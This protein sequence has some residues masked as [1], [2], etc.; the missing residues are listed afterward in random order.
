MK[1]GERASV[2]PWFKSGPTHRTRRVHT[3]VNRGLAAAMQVIPIR[4]ITHAQLLPTPPDEPR[5][6]GADA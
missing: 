5:L 1:Q 3:P 2:R 6:D 4:D